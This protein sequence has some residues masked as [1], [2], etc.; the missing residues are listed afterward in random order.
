MESVLEFLRRM[1][2][3]VCGSGT[4]QRWEEE[5]RRVV[6]EEGKALGQ[7]DRDEKPHVGRG[8]GCRTVGWKCKSWRQG[9]GEPATRSNAT[10]QPQAPK[11]L[12]NS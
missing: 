4:R 12:D 1:N 11:P 10:I 6:A 3:V 8:G 5:K 9:P 2:W 7:T